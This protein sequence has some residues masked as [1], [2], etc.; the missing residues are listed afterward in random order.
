M[1]SA[2]RPRYRKEGFLGQRLVVLPPSVIEAGLR[3]P[4]L[5]GLLPT[6]AGF[7]PKARGHRVERPD[8]V[9]SHV[10]ILCLA[11]KG[12]FR[13]GR[14][15]RVRPVA[16]GDALLLPASTPHAYGAGDG[17]P[18][19]IEW[20]HFAGREAPAWRTA[21]GLA[22]QDALVSVGAGQAAEI[23]LGRVHPHLER[24]H[25]LPDLLAAA[26]ALRF[27]LAELVR[28]RSISGSGASARHAVA[29]SIERMRDR[30]DQ[31]PQLA[32][33]AAE[34]GLSVSHYSTLFRQQT[35]LSPIDYFLRIRLQRA[36]LLLDTTD[37]RVQ[38]IG[39]SLGYDD[40]YYFSRQ[41]KRF[42]SRSPR[43][44]RAVRKG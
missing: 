42:M 9:T 6:D 22:S 19:S 44:Y 4:L 25:G 27:S 36:A 30:L 11:G 15:P 12:W 10:L 37:M 38:E 29:R 43:A 20:A 35:G 8:G 33:I 34:S 40:A 3:H 31:P 1:A 14:D 7:F 24:G 39:A 5:S 32:E 26:A 28:R 21:L 13:L 16:E 2:R 23:R 41:F 18:W 17:A